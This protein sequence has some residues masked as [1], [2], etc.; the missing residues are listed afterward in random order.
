MISDVLE[1]VRVLMTGV[2]CIYRYV[3]MVRRVYAVCSEKVERE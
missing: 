1:V 2:G 3:C